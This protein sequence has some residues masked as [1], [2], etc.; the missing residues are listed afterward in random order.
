MKTAKIILG[1]TAL[2]GFGVLIKRYVD[3]KFDNHQGITQDQIDMLMDHF[4]NPQPHAEAPIDE[5]QY[6]SEK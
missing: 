2:V 5:P 6:S 4:T 1:L 3:S